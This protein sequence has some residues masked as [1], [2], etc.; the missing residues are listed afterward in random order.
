MLH[1]FLNSLQPPWINRLMRLLLR[2]I[3]AAELKQVR[4]LYFMR[5]NNGNMRFQ[6]YLGGGSLITISPEMVGQAIGPGIYLLPG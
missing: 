4:Y 3:K 1:I 6:V 2:R 5:E